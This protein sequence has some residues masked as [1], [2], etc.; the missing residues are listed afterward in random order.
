MML[1]HFE[2]AEILGS[3]LVNDGLSAGAALFILAAKINHKLSLFQAIDL[4]PIDFEHFIDEPD[5]DRPHM[6]KMF[7]KTKHEIHL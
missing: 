3:L 4:E 5:L 7:R 1:K 6:E 2:L